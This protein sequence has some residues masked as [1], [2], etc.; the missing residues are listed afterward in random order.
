MRGASGPVRSEAFPKSRR[1]L[2]PA[3]FR[4]VYEEG[5]RIPTRYFVAF[6]WAAPTA[7]GPKTGFT[8]PRVLGKATRRNRMRR[9]LREIVRRRLNRLDPR[10]RIV[11]NLRRATLTATAEELRADVERVFER[12]GEV[13]Q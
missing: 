6:C 4:Q 8:T 10:W 1:L 5:M 7:D 11:W 13:P 9:R 3:E 2:K 12:C